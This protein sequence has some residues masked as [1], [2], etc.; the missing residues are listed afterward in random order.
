VSGAARLG[1]SLV[2]VHCAA[3]P[4]GLQAA[5]DAA[6]RAA[7]AG[8]TGLRL[9]GVTR[10]TSE[11][12]RL[13][14]TVLGAAAEAHQAHLHGVTAAVRDGRAIKRRFGP[15]FLLL[16]PGIRPAGH[17]VDDQV[18]VATPAEAVRA[19]A[20]FLV[21]GRP[22]TGAPDPQAAASAVLDE[23]ARAMR[24]RPRASAEAVLS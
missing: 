7:N 10:L 3:G 21:V 4:A 11:G 19:G 18:R 13:G 12:G 1:A 22:I 6:A 8:H 16:T 9:L 15:G 2:T 24:R 23:I 14:R 20:D 17:T 5:A